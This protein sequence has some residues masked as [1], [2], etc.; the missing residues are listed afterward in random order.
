MAARRGRDHPK[1]GSSK[2]VSL[3]HRS[4]AE[5]DRVRDPTARNGAENQNT[6]AT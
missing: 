4:E 3:P 1:N 5:A 2:C 6:I